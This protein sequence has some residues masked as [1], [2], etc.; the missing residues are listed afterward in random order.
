MSLG[1]GSEASYSPIPT[2]IVLSSLISRVVN[3][4]SANW[5]GSLASVTVMVTPMLLSSTVSA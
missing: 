3:A 5:G 2:P 1:S 4:P